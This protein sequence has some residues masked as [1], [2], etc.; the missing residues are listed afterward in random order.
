MRSVAQYWLTAS[1]RTHSGFVGVPA[2]STCGSGCPAGAKHC[3]ST[4]TSGAD[5]VPVEGPEADASGAE[6]ASPSA[7]AADLRDLLLAALGPLDRQP[8][9]DEV[10]AAVAVLDLD[11]VAGAAEATDLLREDE[12]HRFG[13]RQR[14]ALV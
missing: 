4:P 14:A 10:V 3:G 5:G 9:R 2:A 11:D 1:R 13:S 7:A 12:L 6:T 8:A